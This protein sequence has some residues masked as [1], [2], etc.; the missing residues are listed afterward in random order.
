MNSSSLFT[1]PINFISQCAWIDK[2]A[3]KNEKVISWIEL[4]SAAVL[5][6][7]IISLHVIFLFHAGPLWRDEV[8]TVN[9]ANMSSITQFWQNLQYDSFPVLWYIILK[10]WIFLGGGKTDMVLRVLG[11][12]VGLGVL[13]ALWYATRSFGIRLPLISL[14]LFALCPAIFIGDTMRAYGMGTLLILLSLVAIWRAF[15]NPATWRIVAAWFCVLLSVHC[16]YHNSFLTFAICSGA[17][18]AGLYRRQLKL[19]I[20]PLGIGFLAALSILPYFK[21]MSQRGEWSIIMNAPVDL[22]WIIQRF[23]LA[24][25]NSGILFTWIWALLALLVFALLIILLVKPVSNPVRPQ[26]DTAVFILVTLLLGIAAYIIFLKI[27]SYPTQGWYYLPLM[28]VL[29][30]LMEK[31]IDLIC[32]RGMAA[33]IIRIIFIIAITILISTDSWTTAHTRRTNVDLLT[34]RLETH[35]D[36]NDLIVIRPFYYGITFKRYYKGN[37]LWITVPEINDLVATRQD[38]LKSIMTQNDPLE[39]VRRKIIKTLQNGHRVWL[40]GSLRFLQP[41]EMPVILPP[42]PHSLYGWDEVTYQVA[43]NQEVSYTLQKYGNKFAVVEIPFKDPVNKLENPSLFVV[44][45]E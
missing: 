13:S 12:A 19:T 4:V 14:A 5:M 8:C 41:A 10:G 33:R 1:K 40:I 3:T 44:S 31:V 9:L 39:P 37:I 21:I 15:Q 24:F 38:I 43:W 34:A 30:V 18:V 27:L 16:L 11:L 22:P 42:A 35:A 17:A 6:L 29:V 25:E 2:A 26:K 7:I 28:A 32:Q 36:Q 23:Q 20:F 45:A